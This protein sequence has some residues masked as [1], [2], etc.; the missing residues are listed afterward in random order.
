VEAFH[1]QAP[2]ELQVGRLTEVQGAPPQQFSV[3]NEI[4]LFIVVKLAA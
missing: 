3:R 2:V 1:E 4:R